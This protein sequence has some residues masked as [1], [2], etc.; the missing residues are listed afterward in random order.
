MGLAEGWQ[1]PAAH[2]EG[3]RISGTN[4]ILSESAIHD[5]YGPVER[6]GGTE[7]GSRSWGGIGATEA[8]EKG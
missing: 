2:S 3:R 1:M 5:D 4:W 6:V 8:D 7:W